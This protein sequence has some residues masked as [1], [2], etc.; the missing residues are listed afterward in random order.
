MSN[1]M[2]LRGQIECRCEALDNLM[3]KERANSVIV[4]TC[5][6]VVS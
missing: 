6:K 5:T 4:E 1:S 3:A 2:Q